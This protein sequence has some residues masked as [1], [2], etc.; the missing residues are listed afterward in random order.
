MTIKQFTTLF[1][2][3]ALVLI[4]PLSAPAQTTT[5]TTTLSAAVNDTTSTFVNLTSATNV[6]A[7]GILFFTTSGESMTVLSSYVSGTRIP[8]ARGA[9]GTRAVKHPNSEVVVVLSAGNQAR[10]G[11]RSG[12]LPGSEPKGACTATAEPLLPVFNSTTNSRYDCINSVWVKTGILGSVLYCGATSGATATCTPSVGIGA[13]TMAGVAT[14]SSNASV[15][16]FSPAF[17]A[18]TTFSCVGND[19][20]TRANVV[21]VIST[22][23]TSITIT[24]TTGASDV[25]NWSCVGY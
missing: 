21:Q 5:T 8:V 15:I 24:N 6:T 20:T 18:T 11:L 1:V 10:L 13:R 14:L 9:A 23:T 17:T 19:I 4:N 7:N 12:P 16:T 3:L 25:I 22:S 2:A